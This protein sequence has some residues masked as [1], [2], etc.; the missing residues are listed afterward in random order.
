MTPQLDKRYRFS[1][2]NILGV[3]IDAVDMSMTVE[4]IESAV[5]DGRK[6]YVCVAGVHGVMEAFRDRNIALVFAN[7]FLVVPDGM[8]TVWIG[9]LQGLEQMD[10]VFGPDL[11]RLLIARSETT[12]FSHFLC[13]GDY[14]VAEELRDTLQQ[15][16]PLA[17]IVGTYTPPFR[18][19]TTAEEHWLVEIL[20]DLNPDI[21]WV[22]LSTP[23]QEKFM[24]RLM[25]RL[26]PTVMIGVGAAFDFHTGRIK[27][28]PAWVKQSGLQWC[29]RLM[30]EPSRLWKRYLVN[31]SQFL[32]E[33]GM[34]LTGM[35]HF[36]P[37]SRSG[38]VHISREAA[39]T[40]DPR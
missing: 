10:R 36:D 23:K 20:N 7:A 12:G 17:R 21:V 5:M 28:S 13:G 30:Q 19:M 29:H 6:G 3:G 38:D 33:I 14:G 4:V 25:P 40:R 9:H 31:N 8:P 16:F 2:A 1:A 27:D 37:P 15:E 26:A 18:N 35:K 22:G 11:M 34:Q 32:Y 24:A 39:T